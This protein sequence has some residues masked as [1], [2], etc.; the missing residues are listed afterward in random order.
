[1]S[2]GIYFL[3]GSYLNQDLQDSRIFR[4]GCPYLTEIGEL[5]DTTFLRV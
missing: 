1:M 2:S 5:S 3:Y 4:I